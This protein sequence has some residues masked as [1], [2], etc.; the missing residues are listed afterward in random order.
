[1][2]M[3]AKSC[4][5]SYLGSANLGQPRQKVLKTLSQPMAGRSVLDCHATYEAKHK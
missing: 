3:V 4:N 2:G 1:M 5:P